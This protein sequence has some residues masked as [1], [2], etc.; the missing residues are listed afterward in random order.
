MSYINEALKKAQESKDS[1]YAKYYKV[2]ETVNNDSR[3]LGIRVFIIS[4][5]VVILVIL[6]FLGYKWIVF[7]HE[8]KKITTATGDT[9]RSEVEEKSPDRKALYEKAKGLYNE[10]QLEDAKKVYEAVVALDAGFI[11][12]LNNLGI[13]YIQEKDFDAARETFEKAIR[14][15]PSYVESYYNLACL[16]AIKGDIDQG[17]KYLEKAISLD[18]NVKGWAIND[19]DLKGLKASDKFNRMVAQ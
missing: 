7:S 1:G 6:V 3:R 4:A 17:L 18:G 19:S 5:S 13:I 9:G 16:Y 11:E 12:A 15:K 2:P 14:L 8:G 10:G